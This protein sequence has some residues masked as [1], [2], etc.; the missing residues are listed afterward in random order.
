[1]SIISLLLTA[2]GLLG[3]LEIMSSYILFCDGGSRGN[4]GPAASGFVIY[5]APEGTMEKADILADLSILEI[6]FQ[7]GVFLGETTNNVAEWTGLKL[8][9]QK[10]LELSKGQPSVTIC[11]DSELVVK[12]VKGE[13]KVKH[14]GLQPLS[15]AVKALLLDY[16]TYRIYH[17]YREFNKVADKLANEA[18]DEA[19]K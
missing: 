19:E 12:Q 18:M 2:S 3:S 11:L 1:L 7:Q 10:I 16:K 17:V 13:Y 15:K 9:L 4:P 5:R 14:P 6:E 8:G